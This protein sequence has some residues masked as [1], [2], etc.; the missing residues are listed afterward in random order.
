MNSINEARQIK[1]IPTPFRII[2][3]ERIQP[4]IL[5][6]ECDKETITACLSD[7]RLVSI[8]NGWYKVLREAKLEQLKNV[9]IM[10]AKRGIYWPDLE[11]FLS[12]KA[13]THGLNSACC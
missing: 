13:F 7:G 3:V 4:T 1:E 2:E 6:V 9:L 11:E 10:P 12:I 8:P 5:K